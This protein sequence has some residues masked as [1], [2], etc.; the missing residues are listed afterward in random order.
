M[1]APITSPAAK[2]AAPAP[3]GES[4]DR[5]RVRYLEPGTCRVHVGLHGALTA[6]IKG[7]GTYGGVFTAYAFPVAHPNR[8]ISLIQSTEESKGLELGVIRDLDQFPADQAKLIREALQRRYFIHKIAR[9]H[10]IDWKFGFVHFQVDTDKGPLEF[11]MRW[12]Q[13][14]AVDYG[15]GGKV[16]IDVTENRFLIPDIESLTP[17]ERAKF[18][19]IIYW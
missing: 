18:R 17:P 5:T 6:T 11:L 2:P 1:E 15:Q 4:I 13:D 16:L 10:E 12:Q 3:T 19:R 9:I 8:F 7:E 14:R